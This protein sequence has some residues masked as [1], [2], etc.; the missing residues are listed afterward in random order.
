[1]LRFLPLC[2]FQ[3]LRLLKAHWLRVRILWECG[4]WSCLPLTQWSWRELYQPWLSILRAF[5]VQKKPQ[6]MLNTGRSSGLLSNLPISAWR[7]PPDPWWCS[8]A[9]SSPES[10][11]ACLAISPSAGPSFWST[12][13][14]SPLG[15]SGEPVRLRKRWRA[16]RSRCGLSGTATA[17]W[18]GRW[19]SEEAS[20]TRRWSPRFRDLRLVTSQ[21]RSCW[22]SAP[23][24]CWASVPTYQRVGCTRLAPYSALPTSSSASRRTG[25]R[26]R[27]TWL[28]PW[29]EVHWLHSVL[30]VEKL[31]R[32]MQPEQ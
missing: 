17:T 25:C 6:S 13:S 12:L 27:L 15:C 28:G 5:L 1:M 9:S 21:L 10:S 31:G 16:P 20:R 26:S 18:I 32:R 29:A 3:A 30:P 23:S 4:L 22:C 2:R 24:S 8:C 11:S 19:S 14:F 7:S